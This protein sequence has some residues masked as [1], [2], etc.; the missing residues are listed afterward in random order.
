MKKARNNAMPSP[1][2]SRRRASPPRAAGRTRRRAESLRS[3]RCRRP[4]EAI[5][6][7]P[8]AEPRTHRAHSR[9]VVRA[10]ATTA[11]GAR[12]VSALAQLR[13]MHGDG[14][15]SV[16][17]NVVAS[18]NQVMQQPGQR[19]V[20]EVVPLELERVKQP[21]ERAAIVSP[22]VGPIDRQRVIEAGDAAKVGR[23]GTPGHRAGL[24]LPAA[25]H[26]QLCPA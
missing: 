4:A 9:L 6:P 7:P 25:D 21:L 11:A 19:S 14:H 16:E 23:G 10:A 26:R 1:P 15:D 3:C 18:A 2:R 20:E 13:A 24:A 8:Q 22:G 17:V 12:F 5:G